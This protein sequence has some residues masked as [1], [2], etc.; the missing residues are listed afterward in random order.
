MRTLTAAA[1]LLD[2][3]RLILLSLACA[4][5]KLARVRVVAAEAKRNE[6]ATF[7]CVRML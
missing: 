4:A 5:L 2:E 6:N 3:T 7:R 1:R